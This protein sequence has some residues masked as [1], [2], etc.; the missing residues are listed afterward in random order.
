MDDGIR[1][2][3]RIVEEL[4]AGLGGRGDACGL[5]G[6]KGAEADKHGGVNGP[7]VEEEGADDCLESS[8]S[9]SAKFAGGASS[10]G[11]LGRGP[12][13]GLGPAGGGRWGAAMGIPQ[14]WAI[15]SLT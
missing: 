2:G 13:D 12:V 8:D 6:G 11:E 14:A 5:G 9:A 4:S 10:F 1:M 7:G 15:D 3:G